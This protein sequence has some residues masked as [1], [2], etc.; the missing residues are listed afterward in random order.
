[1]KC[2]ECKCLD[3]KDIDIAIE[4]EMYGYCKCDDISQSAKQ[5]YINALNKIRESVPL[6]WH[7]MSRELDMPYGSLLRLVREEYTG[8]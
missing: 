3:H 8:E 2:L 4:C 7:D 1:M 6:S 5:E